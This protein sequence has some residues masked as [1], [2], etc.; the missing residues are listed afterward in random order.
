MT[1]LVLSPRY[2]PDSI[3]LSNA[4]VEMGWLVERLQSWRPPAHLVGRPVV[5][6]GEPLFV[7]V[8]ADTLQLALIEPGFSWVAELPFDLRLREVAFTNLASARKQDQRAFIKPADDKCF[9]AKVYTSGS[10]LPSSQMLE[11]SVPIL[12]SEPVSWE[13]EF[14]CFALANRPA[15]FSVY[16]REGELAQ[17]DG[18]NW[19]VSTS[20]SKEA[21]E[22]LS[23]VLSDS[24]VK[25]P[26]AAV[27]DVGVIRDRGWAVVEA[28]ACWGSGIYGCDPRRVLATLS[29]A[30]LAKAALS[31]PDRQW[32][33]E[34]SSSAR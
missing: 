4:A 33:I 24:R 32:I 8:V 3:A 5:A 23:K 21:F 7:A 1:T 17:D 25:F 15:T 10:E 18:G 16:S 9:P 20:E 2:T 6:Y 31:D 26:P 30:C 29:R 27:L 19:P 12:I 28:N 34:R 11:G 22:F 14:R 13:I